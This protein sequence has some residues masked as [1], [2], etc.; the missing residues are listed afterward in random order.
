MNKE[1]ESFL[2]KKILLVRIVWGVLFLNLFGFF[3]VLSIINKEPADWNIGE[4]FSQ[5]PV[6]LIFTIISAICV[7]LSMKVI[8]Y[9]Q[10]SINKK[11]WTRD[12]YVQELTVAQTEN[13]RN[14]YSP[15]E[16]AYFQ[17]LNDDQLK[18]YRVVN[19]L[20]VAFILRFALNE[21]VA[22]FGFLLSAINRN[23]A[24]FY[25]FFTVSL[26]LMVISFP[27]FSTFKF[28]V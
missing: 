25:P 15:A 22:M 17:T 18:I 28:K 3:I 13:G 12:G 26:I 2:G 27:R 7:G 24:W 4:T 1:F 14:Q 9:F 5:G 10:N 21:S 8:D 20:F 23:N 6:P 19:G 16:I 11:S